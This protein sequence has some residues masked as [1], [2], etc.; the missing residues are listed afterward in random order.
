MRIQT[1]A[2]KRI[3]FFR[4]CYWNL[5]RSRQR[6]QRQVAVPRRT[7]VSQMEQ[8]KELTF[9]IY[10]ARMHHRRWGP[11]STV[12]Q[13]AM[14]SASVIPT[15]GIND[16]PIARSKWLALSSTCK[17]SKVGGART[18]SDQL[19]EYIRQWYK[20]FLF[21]FF[22]EGANGIKLMARIMKLFKVGKQYDILQPRKRC[23]LWLMKAVS[24]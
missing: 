12:I 2:P 19:F 10:N 17:S 11:G 6:L 5:T 21:S 1:L 16:A 14:R 22:L 15:A 4:H 18:V 20:T 3:R 24:R 8:Q 13:K 23:T 7:L 9:P